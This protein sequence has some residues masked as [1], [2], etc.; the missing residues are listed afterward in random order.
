[1]ESFGFHYSDVVLN[2]ERI[3]DE[4]SNGNAHGPFQERI[5]ISFSLYKYI[6]HSDTFRYFSGSK[7]EF[8]FQI[9]KKGNRKKDED[10][11]V[12]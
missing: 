4:I 9:C 7:S 5:H 6:H 10:E 3:I 8:S 2:I 1:M 12:Y 11:N